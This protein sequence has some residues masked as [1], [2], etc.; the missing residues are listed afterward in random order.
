MRPWLA[1]S[2]SISGCLV[3]GC[4]PRGP[5][6]A[7]PAPRPPIEVAVLSPSWATEPVPY[8][9]SAQP[10][11]RGLSEGGGLHPRGVAADAACADET[12]CLDRVLAGSPAEDVLVVRL[13]AL[14]DTVLVRAAMIDRRRGTQAAA[15]QEVVHDATPARVDEALTAVGAA[16]AAPYA[17]PS[18]PPP[19]PLV[20]TPWF[21]GVVTGGLAVTGAAVLAAVLASQR[22]PDVVITPP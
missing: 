1:L 11:I 13:A 2:C 5:A 17:P 19:P 18:P 3:L 4:A 10:L 20:K 12:G 9:V 22:R 8:T 6:P 21:W 15:R 7:T 16:L 14:G